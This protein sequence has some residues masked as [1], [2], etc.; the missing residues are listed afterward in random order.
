MNEMWKAM[1]RV[2]G[3]IQTYIPKMERVVPLNLLLS[4][5]FCVHN[6]KFHKVGQR[7]TKAP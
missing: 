7:R 3:T 1:Y 2:K 6:V 4:S 5:K